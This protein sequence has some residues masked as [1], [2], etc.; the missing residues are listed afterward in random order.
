RTLALLTLGV[1]MVNG[2]SGGK[3]LWVATMFM[4]CIFAFCNLTPRGAPPT[5]ANF[6]RIFNL[7]IRGLGFVGILWCALVFARKTKNG[8][9]N[10]LTLYPLHINTSWSRILGLIA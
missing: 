6:W 4:S 8:V 5:S 9:S 10:I 2:E 3:P 1:L 7:C